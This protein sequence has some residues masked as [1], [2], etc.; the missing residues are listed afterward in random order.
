[1]RA[2]RTPRRRRSRWA[3]G[4]RRGGGSRPGSPGGFRAR[5][6]RSFGGP[7]TG[8][9]GGA[10]QYAAGMLAPVREGE[11]GEDALLALG[12]R[13]SAGSPAFCAQLAEASGR[14]PGLRGSGTLAV[15]RDGDEAAELDR[16]FAF[17]RELGL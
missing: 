4:R 5:H 11:F 9:G 3:G 1:M 16:L 12:L 8:R 14:D 15:A 2:R 6:G 17:R 7:P 10:G 13:A